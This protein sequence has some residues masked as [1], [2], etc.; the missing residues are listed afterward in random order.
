MFG[1]S[2]KYN[3][4]NVLTGDAKMNFK[5]ANLDFVSNS[6]TSLVTSNGRAYLKG[7]GTLN[8]NSGYT[9]LA[10]GIDGSVAGGSDLIRFQIKDSSGNVV[11]DSQPGAGD[12]TDPTTLDATGNIRVH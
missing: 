9:F 4:N 2:A 3:N 10:I 1:I 8:G 11:Y 12:T 5:A 6:L 7:S